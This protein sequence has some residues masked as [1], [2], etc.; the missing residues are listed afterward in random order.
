M[1]KVSRCKVGSKLRSRLKLYRFLSAMVVPLSVAFFYFS[2]P[3][4]RKSYFLLLIFTFA[5]V[6]VLLSETCGVR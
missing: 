2:A 1:Y 3:L 4:T 6:Y 5:P